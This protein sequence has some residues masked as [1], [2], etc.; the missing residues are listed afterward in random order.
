MATVTLAIEWKKDKPRGRFEVI[1]GEFAGSTL[2]TGK[3][4]LKKEGFSLSSQGP[5]RIQIAIKGAMV[6]TGPNATRVTVHNGA[7]TFTFFVRDVN[8]DFPIL[9]D[10]YG[11]MVVP[12]VDSRSYGEVAD[13]VHARGGQSVQQRI[14]HEPE[15]SYEN[16]CDG[17]RNE[18]CP[19]WLG[20][21][22]D[23][24][25][26]EVGH[27]AHSS[28]WGYVQPRF[29]SMLPTIPELDNKSYYLNFYIG[30]GDACRH[31]MTRRLD[32]GC[33]PILHA[34]QREEEVT[35]NLTAFATLETSPL[36]MQ[37]LRGSE[38][39]ACYPN[40]N[41]HM[42]KPEELEQVKDLV[43]QE[44]VGREEETVLCIRVTAV[45]TS[46]TPYYA[47]FKTPV[48]QGVGTWLPPT[49]VAYDARLGLSSFKS[50]RIYAIS[51]L[52]GRPAPAEEMA[53]LL[54]PGA[55]ATFEILIPH[56]PLARARAVNLAAADLDRLL[57]ECRAFW[58]SKLDAGA[59]IDV[60][61]AAINERIKAG[62]LHCDIAA[63]GREPDGPVLATI[64]WYS[65]IGSESSPIIQFFDAMGWHKL[66]E[67]SIEFFLARQ[68]EDGFI[69]NFAGYQLE[70]GPALW[71]MGEHFRYTGD[72]RWLRRIKPKLIKACDYLLA[73][74]ERNKTPANRGKGYGLLDGKVADPED[75]FH[76][77]M[78]NGL[79]Y[80]GVKRVAEMLEGIDPAQSRRLDR[81]SRAFREDIRTAFQE[82]VGRSPVIP[83]GDGT[84]VPT[85]PPWAEYAGALAL[86]AEGGKWFTHGAFGARDSIIGAMYLVFSEVLDPDEIGAEIALKSHQHLFTVRNA[87]LTQPYYVRHDHAHL[88]RGE[89]KAFLKIYYNQM[90]ALQDRETYTFWEHYCHASQHKT[91]EEGW[92]LMQTRWMLWLEQDRTLK[93]LAGIPRRWMDDGKSIALRRVASYFGPLDLQVVSHVDTGVIEASI[94]LHDK[95]RLPGS[96][97][98]RLPHP[99]GRKATGVIGG[100]YDPET[101]T[102]TIARFS[103]K[104]EVHLVF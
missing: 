35:Y 37:Q 23:L 26:F 93:L 98:L 34:T 4:S 90:S 50:G 51:R 2:V 84:W 38:W 87:A 52:D 49:N 57:A 42:L 32:E 80:L 79:S 40:T 11:V 45:N 21:S 7:R 99:D 91:H 94:T 77:F 81:E 73:W 100:T 22:R 72:T 71:T 74:R 103:G 67:R 30:K 31:D 36:V 89:V 61:E 59:S 63:L 68:R 29:H 41:G 5:C 65:P 55:T 78:L 28:Y 12:A 96:I 54:Q 86:Y 69:Q 16:A 20:L 15:E 58:K 70:T 102:V 10:L 17:N 88:V 101:E 62:L 95:K 19:T 13:A 83:L 64:G 1:N 48:C 39:Q 97:T 9:L 14:D 27:H 75:F 6:A 46:A 43:K 25:F 8:S 44:T 18:K 85:T 82:A 56:Q 60:P 66:A 24:R 47:W 104:A 3:G 53:V 92:F 76:S 33:L